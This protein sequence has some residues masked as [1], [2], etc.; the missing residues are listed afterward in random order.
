MI[1]ICINEIFCWIYNAELDSFLYFL[2]KSYFA[3]INNIKKLG[4]M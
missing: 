4:P 2:E 1:E 3:D